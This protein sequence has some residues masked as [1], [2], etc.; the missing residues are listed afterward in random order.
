MLRR[1]GTSLI[2]SPT[3]LIKPARARAY[4]RRPRAL[5]PVALRRTTAATRRQLATAA[6]PP[7]RPPGGVRVG[8]LFLALSILGIGATS[9]GLYNFYTSVK[10][11]P[12][13]IRQDLR[14]ALRCKN[15]QDY[16]SSHKFY[17]QAWEKATSPAFIDELGILK[18]TGIGIS[19]AEMLEEAGRRP[20]DG[21]V[22]DA[23]NEAYAVLTETF[24]W[25]KDHMNLLQ[26]SEVDRMR[27]VSIAVKLSEMA[28][29]QPHLDKQTE[30]QLSYA[31]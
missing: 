9:L 16:A 30:E 11:F 25:A 19:W 14:S 20:D 7:I 26:G 1:A 2:E 31:V 10:T 13:E 29:G 28:D 6:N 4:H 18:V 21:G 24:N 12:P 22:A 27:A 8:S 3:A 5:Q 17:N 23:S 15:S